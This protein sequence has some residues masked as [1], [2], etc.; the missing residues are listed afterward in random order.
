MSPGV[1]KWARDA[2]TVSLAVQGLYKNLGGGGGELCFIGRVVQPLCWLQLRVVQP[3]SSVISADQ[4]IVQ[5]SVCGA[6]SPVTSGQVQALPIPVSPALRDLMWRRLCCLDAY[7]PCKRKWGA[8]ELEQER[9]RTR[10]WARERQ[11]Q[12]QSVPRAGG[13]SG[14][15]SISPRWMWS[16]TVGWA[17]CVE[18]LHHTGCGEGGL[19][20]RLCAKC[21]VGFGHCRSLKFLL[22]ALYTV[23]TH[24]LR[25]SK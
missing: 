13:D 18:A 8:R 19:H 2:L 23:V 16:V 25:S 9:V 15:S 6:G 1:S 3:R 7:L 17:R 10:E 20:V 14:L 11:R 24:C 12:R 4:C 21:S 5:V 22:L